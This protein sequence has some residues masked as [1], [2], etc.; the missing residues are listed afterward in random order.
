MRANAYLGTLVLS[1]IV[2]Q[3]GGIKWSRCFRQRAIGSCER[4]VPSWYF[5][6]WSLRCKGF[7][8]SGCGGNSNRFSTEEECQKSCL[9][10]YKRKDVCSLKPKTGKCKAAIPMWYYDSELDECRGLIYG[11]CKGNANRFNTCLSCMKRCSGNKKARKIC[12]KQTAEFLKK[13]N[14]GSEQQRK[15]PRWSVAMRIPFIG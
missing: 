1:L 5:D 10:K 6:I 13:Y 7:L 9:P 2:A 15:T 4:K 12:K 3:A 11:G 14:L 8:Y